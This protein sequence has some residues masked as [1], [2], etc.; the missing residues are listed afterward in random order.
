VLLVLVLV[1]VL[2]AAGAQPLLARALL[3]RHV[4]G[5]FEL[6]AA[7]AAVPACSAC[8][9]LSRGGWPAHPS[10]L[11]WLLPDG[12]HGARWWWLPAHRR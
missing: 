4:A 2:V 6:E 7:S 9:L 11:W 12:V 5:E 10:M 1:L 8:C 3:Q